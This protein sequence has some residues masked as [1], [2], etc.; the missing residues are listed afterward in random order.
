MGFIGRAVIAIISN[1]VALFIAGYFIEGFMVTSDPGGLVL[2]AALLA[3][4]NLVLRPLLKLFFGP[5]MI[6]TF[7]LFTIVVNGIVLYVLDIATPEITIEGYTA[8]LL[9]ALVVSVV[10]V[11]FH[12]GARKAEH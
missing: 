9:G 11:V 2:A 8:L 6:I 10:N 5:F 4:L 7:G 1:A 3:V 12:A